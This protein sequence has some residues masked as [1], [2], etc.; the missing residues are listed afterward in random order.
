ME[1]VL[2]KANTRGHANHGWLDSWHSFSFGAYY[3]PNRLHFGAL[4]VLNDDTVVGGAG[5]GKHPHDNMEIISIPLEGELEHGDSLGNVQ[6]IKKGDVQVMSAGTGV[7]HSEKNRS[8]LLPVRFLQI[9]VFPNQKGVTPRYDQQNFKDEALHN[10]LATIVAPMGSGQGVQ[11]H[12]EAWFSLGK[13]D[14][15]L[16]LEYPLKKDGNGVYAFLIEGDVTINDIV[17]NRRDGLGLTAT[18]P[19]R[20]KANMTSELLLIEVPV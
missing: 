14:A 16:E 10:Q 7:V 1:M 9:W 13:L 17:L 12:Q 2:H 3:D 19:L 15:G 6:V 20:I 8:Q 4:R 5:F 18:N 11:I